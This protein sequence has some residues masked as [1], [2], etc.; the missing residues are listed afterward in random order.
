[1]ANP[2]HI[3]VPIIAQLFGEVA[4]TPPEDFLN[5]LIVKDIIRASI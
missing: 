3:I 1:M 2:T 4:C 5:I